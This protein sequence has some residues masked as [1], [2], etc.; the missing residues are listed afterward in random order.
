M[1]LFKDV[2][3]EEALRR[4]RKKM[5]KE[6]AAVIPDGPVKGILKTNNVFDINNNI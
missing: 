1:R 4:E 6:Q 2:C 5:M 3:H